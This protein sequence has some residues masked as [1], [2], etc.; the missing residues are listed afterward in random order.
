MEGRPLLA[1]SAAFAAGAWFGILWSREAGALGALGFAALALLFS[2]LHRAS[3]RPIRGRPFFGVA[4]LALACS[5]GLLRGAVAARPVLD[6]ALLAWLESPGST[7]GGRAAI[8]AEGAVLSAQPSRGGARLLLRIEARE[9]QPGGLLDP[10]P[11]LLLAQLTGPRSLHRGDR[12][13]ALLQ[14][15]RPQRALNPGAQDLRA[16]LALR[17]ITLIGT[18]DPDGLT[19]LSRG[20]WLWRAID[21]LREQFARRCAEVCTTPDR[22]ALVAALGV[23]DRSMIEPALEDELSESGLVHLLSSA[24]LHLAIVALLAQLLARRVLLATR[25]APRARQLAPLFSVPAALAEV[26][27][28][29]APWPAL[30]AAG[31]AGLGLCAPLLFRRSDALTAL[32]LAAGVC[33]IFDPASTHDL[34]LQLSVAGVLGLILLAAPLRELLPIPRP[35]LGTRSWPRRAGELL[36]QLCCATAAAT[37]CT[38]PLLAAAFH[39]VSIVSVAANALGLGPGLAAVPLATLAIPLDALAPPL[40]LP[41]FWAADGLAGVVLLATH[42][43]AAIPG[44]VVWL[45]APGPLVTL[46][47]LCFVAQLAGLPTLNPRGPAER[48]RPRTRLLRAAVPLALLGCIGLGRTL[49]A[50]WSR[51]VTATFLAVGQGDCALVQLPGGR[52]LLIDAGGDLRGLPA[53]LGPGRRDP[54]AT[55][56]LPALAE[57]GVSRLDL[58][59]LT[60]PHP[61]HAGGLPTLFSHLPV[62]ELWTT[63]EPGPGDIGGLIAQAAR[64]HAIAVHTPSPGTR[65]EL[66]GVRLEV[67]HPFPRWNP[68]RSTNDNS[69]VLRLVHGN[70]ALL[71]A[72]D[73]EALAEAQLA[74]GS[75]PLAAQLL[76][77]PHHG[78][79][80][81]STDAF[82]RRV[83][84]DAVVYSVG[85][86]NPFGFPHPDVLA[87]TRALGATTLLRTD[88]GAI[89]ACSDG[90]RLTVSQLPGPEP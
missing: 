1:A 33:A 52:T 76:K 21:Q 81:S 36:L 7:K 58:V 43:F 37:L 19:L 38:A 90:L 39:R 89:T 23:G 16:E 88:Q 51:S 42:A 9:S 26:L 59:V 4:V 77:A 18:V 50:R 55:D 44:A 84:P 10:P 70:I 24:G 48:A 79:R 74:Q 72:G 54:G 64:A 87:R 60:H 17:G 40:A 75:A 29:G 78:S 73:I 28:I 34:A 11:G 2:L 86:G 32:A 27:L 69:I 85:E 82:L 65:L 14:L 13:R 57:L 15:R 61:D 83:H 56:L 66:D 63:G 30:R 20:P 5:L 25:L 53:P 3:Q 6:T 8:L 47:W 31:G 67:L 45:A 35:P 22:A 12:V 62:G 80:T 68:D 41:L 71:F 46:L 49:R